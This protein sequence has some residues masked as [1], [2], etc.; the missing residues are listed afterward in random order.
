[1]KVKGRKM[2]IT[3]VKYHKLVTLKDRFDN[4]SFGAEAEVEDS[5]TP[6]DARTNLVYWVN[7]YLEKLSLCRDSIDDLED[8]ARRLQRQIEHYGNEVKK[9]QEIKSKALEFLEK[10][11][12][13]V[14][15]LNCQWKS[16]VPF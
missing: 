7:D 1:M 6:E 13:D 12:I 8:E 11:G 14:T 16:E 15:V 9:L 10:H 3:K 2:K 4:V 5:E